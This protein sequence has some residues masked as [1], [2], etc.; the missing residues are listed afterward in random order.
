MCWMSIS[1]TAACGDVRVEAGLAE[2]EEVGEGLL[3]LRVGAG[4][5][6]AIF[7]GQALRP[8]RGRAP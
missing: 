7:L 6:R 8:G 1:S 5:R 3:E 4:G 2:L